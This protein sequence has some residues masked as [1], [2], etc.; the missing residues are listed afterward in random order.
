[1]VILKMSSY[2]PL[3]FSREV[4]KISDFHGDSILNIYFYL[5]HT[6]DHVI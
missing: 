6:L 3:D 5:K 4:P 1:M 2:P